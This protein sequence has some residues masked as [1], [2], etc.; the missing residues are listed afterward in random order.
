MRNAIKALAIFYA[1]CILTMYSC[2]DTQKCGAGKISNGKVEFYICEEMLKQ[3]TIINSDNRWFAD[4]E[5][6]LGSTVS[7]SW[8]GEFDSIVFH[9]PNGY[10]II[11]A[12][13]SFIIVP[14]IWAKE[15]DEVVQYMDFYDLKMYCDDP[16]E[17]KLK[18]NILLNPLDIDEHK[19][20]ELY[21]KNKKG[22]N[23]KELLASLQ[24]QFNKHELK[25]KNTE[26]DENYTASDKK[27]ELLHNQHEK[28]V[29]T[30]YL[31]N[32]IN[33]EK[34]PRE[35][36]ELLSV[37]RYL[38]LTIRNGGNTYKLTLIRKPIYGN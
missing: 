4:A 33:W 24:K 26:L 21:F 30:G 38:T 17:L 13:Q 19:T 12:K 7:D 23:K 14:S 22:I 28:D 10:K 2:H 18:N 25:I 6:S 1:L 5:P 27:E 3:D 11:E 31:S 9:L 8:L 37:E 34:A 32:Y 16:Q 20:N 36:F 29:Y 15:G 35:Q